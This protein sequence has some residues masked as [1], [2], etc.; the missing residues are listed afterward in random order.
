MNDHTDINTDAAEALDNPSALEMPQG[1]GG[2]ASA[3][4]LASVSAE[5]DKQIATAKRYPRP[6]DRILLQ[7]KI[8]PRVTLTPEVAEACTY[9]LPRGNKNIEGPS[10]RLAE[11]LF[12]SWGNCRVAS[13]YLGID[14]ENGLVLVRAAFFDLETNAL[15]QAVE[16]RRITGRSGALFS[17]DMIAVTAKAAAAIAKRNAILGG[18]SAGVVRESY[19][20]AYNY[21]LGDDEKEFDAR[22]AKAMKGFAD[23]FG[24]EPP[25][26]FKLLQIADESQ[27]R[28]RHLPILRGFFNAMVQGEETYES[29]MRLRKAPVQ[30]FETVAH[31]LRDEA[32][33]SVKADREIEA[34]AKETTKPVEAK[35]EP[36]QEAKPEPDEKTEI[37]PDAENPQQEPAKQ[38]RPALKLEPEAQQPTDDAGYKAHAEAWIGAA[39]TA[40]ALS[41]KWNAER[42]LRTR[43]KASADTI[44]H[45]T[46]MKEERINE[47][48]KS[49]G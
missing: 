24:I 31:P 23:R 49:V 40:T 35:A 32:P 22:K 21:A 2:T 33:A 43:C 26:V 6:D 46:E 28:P 45:L 19:Q 44:E 17:P 47:L 25:D 37:K 42:A 30:E 39:T 15:S 11:I 8:I 16:P 1:I 48:R 7:R 10:I 29:L 41:Q 36:K 4:A 3:T 14:R 13:E 12:Q 34:T 18:I 9:S 5:I 38:E 20:A 27:M